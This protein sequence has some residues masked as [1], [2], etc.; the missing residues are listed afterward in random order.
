[1]LGPLLSTVQLE[2]VSMMRQL[3]AERSSLASMTIPGP[4][5]VGRRLTRPLPARVDMVAVGDDD[6]PDPP[7]DA[8]PAVPTVFALLE[9]EG[10]QQELAERG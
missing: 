8:I 7:A 3:Q 4:S 10:M 5:E 2:R 1:M 9:A 6:L